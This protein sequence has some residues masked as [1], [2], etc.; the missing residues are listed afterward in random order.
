[1]RSLGIIALTVAAACGLP[2][3]AS[4]QAA[5]SAA[6]QAAPA[7]PAPEA[8][9]PEAEAQRPAGAISDPFEGFNRSMYRFNDALDRAVLEPVAKGY[10]A[11]TTGPVRAGVR[12][13]L[14]NLSSPVV[15][16]NDALQADAPRAGVTAG[17]FAINTTVGVLGVFDPAE[18]AGLHRHEADFGQTL[19]VWGVGSGPYLYLPLL[20]P[21]SVRDGVGRIV[22]IAFDPFTWSKF[23]GDD[24]FR[25][26]RTVVGAVS[27]REVLIEPVEELRASSIDPYVTVRSLY[28]SLRESAVRKGRQDVQDLPD[29]DEMPEAPDATAPAVSAPGA[30][31]EGR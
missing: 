31:G 21:S 29:F 22:D 19:G 14:R 25:A 7:A 8:E 12:N 15:F 9:M 5:P 18:H 11:V 17:R 24:E 20:G 10:R 26:T 16:V 28:G 30:A 6:P 1:M 27:T 23:D 2:A 13:F 3:S 4:A